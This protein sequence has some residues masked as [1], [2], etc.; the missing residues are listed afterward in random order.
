MYSTILSGA[1]YGMESYLVQVEVDISSGL[2][3][4]AMVGNLGNEVKEA[5]ERVRIALK[6]VGICLPPM[7]VAVNLAPADRRKEGTAYDLPIAVAVLTSMEKLK[8]EDGEGILILGELGLNGEIKPVR[9]VLPIVKAAFFAGI[10]KCLIPLE[11]AEEAALIRGM[12]I[13]GASSVL[14]VMEYLKASKEERDRIIPPFRKER[15]DGEKETESPMDFRQIAGQESVKRAAV[16]A[17]AGFHNMLITGPPGSGKTMIAKR[18]PSILPPLSEEEK[19]E[20][21]SVYSI[22]GI[23]NEKNIMAGKRPF[24]NPHHTISP[25]ALTGGGRKPKPGIISLSHRGVLFLD[26]FPEFKRQTLDALRQPLEDRSVQIARTY[27]TFSYPADFM[28]VGAMNPCPCGYYPDR[29]KCRC[30]PFEIHNYVSHISGP[31]LDRI[32]ICVQAPKMEITELQASKP[33]EDSSSMRK[34]VMA[35]RRLQ[36]DRY[37]GTTLRFNGDL[38]VENMDRYC[39]LGKEEEQMIRNIFQTMDLS[40]RA[41]H[42]MLKV[43]RTIADVEGSET[44]GKEHLAEAACYYHAGERI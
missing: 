40:A 17:A 21:A 5:G 19:L 8:K 43:A 26:E 11:N 18:L 13:A 1:L 14:Q 3:C 10:R 42:R 36:R 32:D 38:S 16:I 27:G 25:Q 15:Y 4:F 23:L 37:K 34:K 29:N 6:N 28:L 41:Y 20:V 12:E 2:P 35:A 7:H 30:T 9:G 33:G 24:L 44:I 22:A 31:V 39:F